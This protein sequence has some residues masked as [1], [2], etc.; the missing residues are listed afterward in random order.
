MNL[1]FDTDMIQ[2]H[3]NIFITKNIKARNMEEIILLHPIE[4]IILSKIS[5]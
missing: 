2:I 3:K 1:Y 4:L 5:S